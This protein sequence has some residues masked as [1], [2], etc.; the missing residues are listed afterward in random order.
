MA[1]RDTTPIIENT[2]MKIY[3]NSEGVDLTYRIR[4]IAN[5]VI[6]DKGRDYEEL[7]P[8]TFEPVLDENGNPVMKQ[9]FTRGEV[10]CSINYDFDANPREFFTRL[11]NEVPADQIFDIGNNHEIM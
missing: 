8:E 11:E 10:S 1:L 4:P 7:D 9:G 3:T 2:T 5:Y 6:H